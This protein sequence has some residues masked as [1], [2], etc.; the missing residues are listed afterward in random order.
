MFCIALIS[1][2]QRIGREKYSRAGSH[3]A[4]RCSVQGQTMT[5]F[6]V[7][8]FDLTKQQNN[9]NPTAN[10]KQMFETESKRQPTQKFLRNG[11]I[12]VEVMN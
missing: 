4:V 3:T 5:S 2:K 1:Q 11:S 8:L 10:E 9:A 12:Y 7:M 6:M